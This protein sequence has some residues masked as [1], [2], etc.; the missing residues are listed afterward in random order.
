MVPLEWAARSAGHE[1]R[2]AGAPSLAGAITASGLPAVALGPAVDLAGSARGKDLSSWH[3]H[4][5]WPADWP[6]RPELLDD[7]RK[8][9]LEALGRRQ[10]AMAEAMLEDLVDFGRHW[11]PDLVVHD[12]VSY[13]GPV[14]A[15]VLGV[16]NISHLWGSPGLQRLEMKGLGPEPQDGYVR[17]FERFGA[18]VRTWPDAWVDPCPPSMGFGPAADV[19]PEQYV[20]Y[21]GPGITPDWLLDPPPGP[22]VC[23]T[24]GATTAKLLGSAMTDLLRQAVQAV[25]ALPVEVVLATTADQRELLGELPATVRTVV[26]L[27]LHLL[28]PTCSAVVHHGGAGTTLT[29]AR[30]GVPQLTITRRPEPALNGERQAVTGAGIHLTYGELSRTPHPVD[31]IREQVTRLLEVPSYRDAAQ[32]LA[33]EITSLPAPT[34]IVSALEKLVPGDGPRNTERP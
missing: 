17:L 29:A 30:S 10:F 4:D 34:D 24:W 7:R 25:A 9:L 6:V 32:R 20:P 26:S 15:S 23:V 18:P 13:A 1:V 14:A 21:N 12:A 16:P 31:A 22:R 2:V 8:G 27:P 5:R 3:D 19:W 28:L 33:A 11:R